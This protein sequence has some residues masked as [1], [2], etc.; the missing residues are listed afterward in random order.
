MSILIHGLAKECCLKSY[1]KSKLRFSR[2]IM[3]FYLG[4]NLELYPFLLVHVFRNN[5]VYKN[6]ID[7]KG[8]LYFRNRTVVI[9]LLHVAI[10]LM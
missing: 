7:V 1:L 4:L 6:I 5:W 3:I 10:D 8:D 2:T 9:M